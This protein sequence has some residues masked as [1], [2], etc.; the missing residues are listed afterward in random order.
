MQVTSLMPKVMI[1]NLKAFQ[2]ILGDAQFYRAL[3]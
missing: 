2:G 1:L 3:Y